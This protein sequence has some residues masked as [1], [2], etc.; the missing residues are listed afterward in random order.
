M[1]TKPLFVHAASQPQV[2]AI[3]DDGGRYTY[4]QLATMA[5]GLGVYLGRQ[6]TKPRVGLL[7]PSGAGFVASFYGT[8]LAGKTVVPI[9]FLLSDHEVAHC[10]ADSG[11]DTVITVPQLA[12]R[13]KGI[14]LNVVDLTQL[15]P[16]STAA[17]IDPRL[18]APAA[19]DVAVLM[20]TS[21][22]SGLPKGVLLTYGNI[23]SDVDAAIAHVN[24]DSKHR[25]LGII[26]LFHAFGMTAMM[27]APIQLG[28]TIVYLSRFS[29]VGTVNAIKEQR[30]SLVLGVPSMYAAI[31]RLKDASAEDFKTIYAVISGGEPLPATLRDAFASRFGVTLLDAYGM[32][33]TSLAIAL[34][35]PQIYKAGSVGKPVPGAQIK[36]V[37]DDGNVLPREQPGEIWVKGP[38]VMQGYHNLPAETAAALTADGYFRTGDLGKLDA[39]GFLHLTG[40]KKDLII[41]A[42]EKVAPREIEEALMAHPAVAEAAVIGKRS[43]SRGEAVIA[44][45]VARQGPPPTTE[46]LRKFCSERGLPAWKVPREVRI[47]QE[48]P[49]SPTGKILKRALVQQVDAEG[50]SNVA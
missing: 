11:I 8:L 28:A 38:M 34:N 23:Q 26:P 36:I 37:D 43:A 31:L 22:T 16:M 45:V 14:P 44:F 1:L 17:T 41:V 39:D 19:Q 13:I 20:Y 25:F 40:R 50:E 35:T 33:E 46:D 3:I 7:L 15:P 27:L 42:G 29:P 49:R 24:F 47:V 9:N 4:Q 32:T 12:G 48:L 5:A 18:P 6:T 2:V 21:G 10:I 30:I